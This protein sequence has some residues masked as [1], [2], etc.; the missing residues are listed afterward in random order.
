MLETKS[1]IKQGHKGNFFKFILSKSFY[2]RNR[3]RTDLFKDI[4][5]LLTVAILM[6][7]LILLNFNT[8]EN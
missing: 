4:M 3:T 6:T 1:S 2:M 7:V 5:I 8:R